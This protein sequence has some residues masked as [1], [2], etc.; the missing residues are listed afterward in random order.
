MSAS[1]DTDVLPA[2]QASAIKEIVDRASVAT[3][4]GTMVPDA[5]Q[6]DISIADAGGTRSMRFLGDPCPAADLFAAIRNLKR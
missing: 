3:D 1:V 5:F 2:D 6:Y 4:H